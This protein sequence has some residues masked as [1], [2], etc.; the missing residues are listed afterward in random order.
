MQ[1]LE[2]LD[3]PFLKF[4]QLKVMG[5]IPLRMAESELVGTLNSAPILKRLGP[6]SRNGTVQIPPR[7]PQRLTGKSESASNLW[8]VFLVA[9]ILLYYCIA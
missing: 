1:R 9:A 5:C 6:P 7:D 2:A 4:I 8:V 3:T